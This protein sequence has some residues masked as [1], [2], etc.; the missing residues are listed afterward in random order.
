MTGAEVGKHALAR[1]PTDRRA[2]LK[3]ARP[4]SE[5]DVWEMLS[6]DPLLTDL[7]PHMASSEM[8]IVAMLTRRAIWPVP[9]TS[10]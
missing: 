9:Q 7:R 1:L 2:L 8:R 10:G 3:A 4:V 5:A 6:L